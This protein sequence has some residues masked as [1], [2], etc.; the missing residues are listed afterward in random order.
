MYVDDDTVTYLRTGRQWVGVSHASRYCNALLVYAGPDVCV[1]YVAHAYL[2][3][4]SCNGGYHR[5]VPTWQVV[6][7]V[8]VACVPDFY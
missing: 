4:V 1:Y 7:A 3:V 5:H 6:N 2:Q 8:L